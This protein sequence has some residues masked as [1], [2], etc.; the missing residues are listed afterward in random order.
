MTFQ[1]FAFARL[2]FAAAC[3]C[4]STAFAENLA[5]QA[6]VVDGDTLE[7]HGRAFVLGN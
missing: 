3:L 7:I 1:S 4:A 5:G 2:L 6:S